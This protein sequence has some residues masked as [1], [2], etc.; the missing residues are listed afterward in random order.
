MHRHNVVNPSK[1]GT[2]ILS[3][4]R[5]GGTQLFNAIRNVIDLQ[6][7]SPECES[8]LK[9]DYSLNVIG[10]VDF[11]LESN[12][13]LLSQWQSI[14]DDGWNKGKDYKLMLINNP[15]VINWLECTKPAY[16]DTQ[17]RLLCNEFEV[18]VLTRKNKIQ[19]IT[20]LPLWER[21][22]KEN[23]GDIHRGMNYDNYELFNSELDV[24]NYMI[25]IHKKLLKKPIP[26][27]EITLGWGGEFIDC[28]AVHDEK[29]SR[30]KLKRFLHNILRL[31]Q[32]EIF[33]L[34]AIQR[35][36]ALFRIHYEEFEGSAYN[37]EKLFPHHEHEIV[38]EALSDSYKKIPYIHSDYVDYFDKIVKELA[39][40]WGLVE[41]EN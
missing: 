17:M 19:C 34:D 3:H 22:L 12:K 14:V 28:A 39:I 9:K 24:T 6:E 37:L 40:E 15:I 7:N 13:T 25:E 33:I 5:S 38:Q 11:D 41:D 26:A 27:S 36:Y 23:C 16:E 35:K 1:K 32:Q 21:L 8:I 30:V 29:V 10:E 18:I 20:S 4:Y 2:I 31:F